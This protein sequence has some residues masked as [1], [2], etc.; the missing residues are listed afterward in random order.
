MN[1]ILKNSMFWV[2]LSV[3]CFL[4]PPL[5]TYAGDVNTLNVAWYQA[6]IG[7]LDPHVQNS[8]EKS[9]IYM[10]CEPLVTMLKDTLNIEPKLATSWKVSDDAKAY[11]F[12]LRKGVKFQDGTPFNAEAVKFNFDRINTLKKGF[13]WMLSSLD[14][15]KVVDEYTVQFMMKDKFGLFLSVM[16]YFPIVSPK[17]VLDHEEKKGD[18]AA[19]WY[20]DHAVGTGPYLFK[21]WQKSSKIIF[22]KF[23]GYWGGWNKKRC[24]KV[25]VWIIP[26]SGTQRM[27]LEKGEL[28]IIQNF[29]VDDFNAYK[30]S[31]NISAAEKDG[32]APTYIRLNYVTGPTANLKVRQALS[33][34]FDRKLYEKLMTVRIQEPDGPCPK[35]LLGGWRPKGL[36]LEYDPEKAKKLLAEAGYPDGFEMS[37]LIYTGFPALRVISEIWQAGLAKAGVTLKLKALPWP[38]LV[39]KLNNWALERN[40][41]TAEN[42]YIQFVGARLP[43][44]YAYLYLVYHSKAQSGNGR[45]WMLYSNPKVDEMT[46]KGVQTAKEKERLELYRKAVQMVADDCPDIFVDKIVDRVLMRNVVKGFYFNPLHPNAVSFADIYKTGP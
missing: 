44:P 39:S 7:N 45:N 18:Y 20:I 28:D 42:S 29:T 15:V 8:T 14:K 21:E 32:V 23:D 3:L 2:I 27:M 13:Y 17:S 6:E 38:S 35:E 33:Y 40:P 12:S 9:I 16:T 1:S 19:K 4:A 22:E 34:C 36:I 46:E 11:T 25:V 43:D 10:T 24:G 41:A 26:E 31:P 37:M 30:G 5:W